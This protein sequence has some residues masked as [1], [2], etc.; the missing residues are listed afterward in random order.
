[1]SDIKISAMTAAT[2]PLTGSELVPLVQGGANVQDTVANLTAGRDVGALSITLSGNISSAAWTTNGIRFKGVAATFTDTTS[3]GTVAAAYTN[4][5]GGNTIAASSATTFTNYYSSYV[6]DPT[7]GSNVT[8]TNKWSFGTAGNVQVGGFT[9]SAGYQVASGA[10]IT[11]STTSR[12]LSAT[13][14]GKI[15]YCTAATAV[16]ITTAVSLGAG[17]SCVIIQGGAGQVG[18]TAAAST[19]VVSYGSLTHVAGQYAM[20][21]VIC[22]VANTFY[23][24]GSMA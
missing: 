18:F 7:A 1:M 10:I 11:E 24:G 3:S 19:T 12:T 23:L 5:Y 6:N 17:F 21:T 9:N 14:N 2:D 13:D 8:F 15:I 22:P 4:V 16:T 20:V